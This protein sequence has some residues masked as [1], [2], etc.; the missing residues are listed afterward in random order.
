MHYVSYV[1]VLESPALFSDDSNE[2]YE[3]RKCILSLL[4]CSNPVSLLI[5][6]THICFH[7]SAPLISSSS[8]YD[9]TIHY[10]I[11]LRS[12]LNWSCKAQTVAQLWFPHDVPTWC[13]WLSMYH[14]RHYV[15]CSW[16]ILWY[17]H[18]MLVYA[19]FHWSHSAYAALSTC[20]C[21]PWT[22]CCTLHVC[23]FLSYYCKSYRCL[24][25]I[26]KILLF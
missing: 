3:T 15:T 22:Q 6:D 9:D 7:G 18:T 2:L 14:D 4:W 20:S 24:K 26:I 11:I 10:I 8:V 5:Y 19:V 17:I 16:Y 21:T 23:T 1:C 13:Y 12:V 25:Y